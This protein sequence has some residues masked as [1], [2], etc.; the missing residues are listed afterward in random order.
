MKT[1]KIDT[2]GLIICTYP[3]IEPSHAQAQA[4]STVEEF[5]EHYNYSE[6][7]TLA[8]NMKAMSEEKG[9][10]YA[11][12]DKDEYQRINGWSDMVIHA[13]HKLGWIHPVLDFLGDEM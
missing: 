2:R 8:A 1:L 3:D 13:A 10:R 5:I 4:I 7:P 9:T 12:I 11:V 6:T